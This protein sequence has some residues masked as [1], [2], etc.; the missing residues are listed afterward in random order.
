MDRTCLRCGKVFS[1]PALLRRHERRKTPCV[2]SPPQGSRK[3]TEKCAGCGRV[4]ATP[5]GLAQH[6]A[7]YCTMRPPHP[8]ETEG[9]PA[10]KWAPHDA[11]PG[12]CGLYNQESLSFLTPELLGDIAAEALSSCSTE[13]EAAHKVFTEVARRALSDPRDLKTLTAYKSGGEMVVRAENGWELRPETALMHVVTVGRLLDAIECSAQLSHSFATEH[14]AL[15]G[16]LQRNEAE[17]VKGGML[18]ELYVANY[19][20]LQTLS[21]QSLDVE[22]GHWGALVRRGGDA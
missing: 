12:G 8:L 7:R 17:F 10:V 14:R 3:A 15:L 13:D 19:G 11:T 22:G 6:A 21:E 16:A 2:S 1:K 9:C 5:A 4:F 18:S 20:H